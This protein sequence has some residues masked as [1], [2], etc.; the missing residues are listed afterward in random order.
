V[1]FIAWYHTILPLDL[2]EWIYY[3]LHGM[4]GVILPF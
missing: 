2:L 4:T 3:P 1:N